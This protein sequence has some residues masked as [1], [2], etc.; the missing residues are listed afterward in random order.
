MKNNN[1]I[2][3]LDLE[4][5]GLYAGTHEIIEAA[6]IINDSIFHV[7]VKPKNLHLAS[8]EALQINGYSSKGWAD[9]IDS[10]YLAHKLAELLEGYTIIGHN[11]RFD[12]EFIECLFEEHEIPIGI[13]RRAID[14]I[15]LSYVYLRPLGLKSMSLDSIREF[16]GWTVRAQHN[17]LDDAFDVKRLYDLLT[18][19]KYYF[20]YISH[21]ANK[22]LGRK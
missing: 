13:N 7:K 1:K 4:T 2:A 18:T 15:T 6:V 5:T 11:P 14:T 21:Y 10:K 22:L 3:F 20:W 17:A 9:A 8:E 19:K 12:I 16:L